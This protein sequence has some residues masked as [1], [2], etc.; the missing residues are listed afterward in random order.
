LEPRLLAALTGGTGF[1]GSHL[2]EA[3]VGAGFRVRALARR[4]ED[5][6]W[7]KNMP[8]EIVTGDV[9]D[10]SCLG[11]LVAGA[12]AVVHAAGKTSARSEDEYMASN[13]GGTANVAR[14]AEQEAPDAHFVLVS[15]QAAAG[16][17]QDGV[18]VS[19]SA[20]GRP[21]SAYG[22]SK[23]EGENEVR[24]RARL[25]YTILRPCAVYG[26][27]ETAIRDL[28]VAASK[29]IVPVFAGGTPRIQLVYAA[30]VAGALLGALRRGGRRETF[31][32]A[33]PEILDYRAIAETLAGLPP[34]RPLLVPVPAGLVRLAG[35]L[36]GAASRLGTSPP[37]FNS[38]KADE[39]LQ[40][41]WLCDV[42][43]TQAALGEPLRTDFRSG[44]RRTWDWYAEN[45]W[46]RS[47][48]IAG[49]KSR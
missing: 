21:V 11:A 34:K 49:R 36:V 1:V 20:P 33:H 25:S 43:G 12:S 42:S 48:N 14:A 26:P 27:R 45:G 17:S 39:M 23:L 7:L 46:I 30:D 29:G 38:E 24:S 4:P 22:R 5:P 35:V 2:A 6:G 9:R 15:S 40:A 8:V 28:F 10:P 31:F 47:D 3:L 37:I 41:A 16:P 44:A 18:P 32:V 13:A 19:A